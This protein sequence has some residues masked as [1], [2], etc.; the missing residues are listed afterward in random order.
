MKPSLLIA[1]VLFVLSAA[2]AGE[3]PVTL[4]RALSEARAANAKLPLPAYDVAIAREQVNE[5]RAERWLKVA[6]EGEFVYAP[7]SG[8][9]P[10]LTNLGEFRLQ[11]VIP[12][13]LH[14]A[15]VHDISGAC[16]KI[17]QPRDQ[18]LA[19]GI[20]VAGRRRLGAQRA[21]HRIHRTIARQ[22]VAARPATGHVRLHA[23]GLAVRRLADAG[24]DQLGLDLDTTLGLAHRMG[25][26]R[27]SA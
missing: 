14:L 3:E 11:A 6:V 8:Y 1:L 24:G 20:G 26:V 4:E 12:L 17:G 5:A 10:A 16:L 2:A 27:G 7:P 9:D 21:D 13:C 15:Q 18:A 23:R 25:S 22:L 19:R